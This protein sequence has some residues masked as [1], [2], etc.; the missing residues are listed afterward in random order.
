MS[1]SGDWYFTGYRSRHTGDDLEEDSMSGFDSDWDEFGYESLNYR[2]EPDPATFDPF[3]AAFAKAVQSM[4]VPKH[5]KLTS[6][7][8]GS[9]GKF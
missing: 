5:F 8:K 6:E 9:K 1:T 3:L 2:N 7:F 4:P